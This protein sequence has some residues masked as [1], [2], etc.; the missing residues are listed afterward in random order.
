[1]RTTS[2]LLITAALALAGCQT[3]TET[4]LVCPDVPEIPN[5]A[6]PTVKGEDLMCLSDD[7]FTRLEMLEEIRKAHAADLQ[8]TLA[9]IRAEC[10][11]LEDE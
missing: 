11:R 8:A 3:I 4:R 5:P 1:M 9:G 10:E 7:A 6:V 2:Y